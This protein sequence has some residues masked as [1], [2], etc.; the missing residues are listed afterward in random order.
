MEL[1]NVQF[2]LGIADNFNDEK[3]DIISKLPVE[4]VIMILRMLDGETLLRVRLVNKR[5]YDISK[6][7]RILRRK[8]RKHLKQKKIERVGPVGVVYYVPK[9][10]ITVF[11]KRNEQYFYSVRPAIQS[12]TLQNEV[13]SNVPLF[14]L[15]TNANANVLRQ[16]QKTKSLPLRG[17]NTKQKRRLQRL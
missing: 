3:F 5:W 9:S 15:H 6:S 11:R 7:D 12:K 16:E 8:I 4:I 13:E 2:M 14:D 10:E 17:I 1:F